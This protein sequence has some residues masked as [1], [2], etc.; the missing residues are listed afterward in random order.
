MSPKVAVTTTMFL[1]EIQM[2]VVRGFSDLEDKES[3]NEAN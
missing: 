2:T 1:Q 3:C